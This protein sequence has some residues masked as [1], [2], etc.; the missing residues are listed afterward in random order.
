MPLETVS[1]LSESLRGRVEIADGRVRVVSPEKIRGAWVGLLC[2]A[3]RE[4]ERV[5]LRA[6]ARWILQSI[7]PQI[8][9]A[10]WVGDWVESRKNSASGSLPH[11]EI[12]P[13][14][15]LAALRPLFNTRDDSAITP[16]DFYVQWS[17][18]SSSLSWADGVCVSV[19]AAICEGFSGGLCFSPADVTLP[20]FRV[21]ALRRHSP[22]NEPVVPQGMSPLCPT[23]REEMI[24][25]QGERR[26]SQGKHA[27]LRLPMA[28]ADLDIALG[29][30]RVGGLG[31]SR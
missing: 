18:V 1:R 7:A 5:E 3:A 9:V 31:S 20:V 10:L 30:R 8:G 17:A 13:P 6:T 22:A 2:D 12:P 21:T 14:V 15:T 25:A 4:G 24:C 23:L 16:S 27:G 19:T 29:V 28:R 11:F 26:M